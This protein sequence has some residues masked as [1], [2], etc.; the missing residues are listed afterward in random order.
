MKLTPSVEKFRLT[1]ALSGL[2]EA[3]LALIATNIVGRK[4][5]ARSLA[6]VSFAALRTLITIYAPTAATI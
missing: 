3:A 1:T 2:I 5:D 4:T 6:F